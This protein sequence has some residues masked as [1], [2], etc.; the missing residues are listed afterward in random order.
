MLL[1]PLAVLLTSL[2]P[3]MLAAQQTAWIKV[4]SGEAASHLLKKVDPEY[5]AF[6]KAAGIQ[7]IVCM[8][9]DI[10]S[11]GHVRGV[12]PVSGSP[13]LA[14]AAANA[15]TQYLYKPFVKDGKPV[16][17]TAI[18][19][20]RFVLPAGI[21]PRTYELPAIASANFFGR[22]R[23]TGESVAFSSLSSRLQQWFRASLSDNID[24]SPVKSDQEDKFQEAIGATTVNL[25]PGKDPDVRVYL[26]DTEG[27]GF[28]GGPG[29]N[30]LV[31]LVEERESE[32]HLITRTSANGY[33]LRP[34][35]GSA[36]PDVFLSHH[37]GMLELD[38]WGYSNIDGRWG[39]LYCGSIVT[40]PPD[41]PDAGKTRVQICP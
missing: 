11:D 32:I 41:G 6:A 39:Q 12:R 16:S 30:C 13:S 28:C 9:V 35:P 14:D 37:M 33:F 1:R 26:F 7:G 22:G 36:Y 40:N 10:Y 21:V 27:R 17:T 5:P 4:S 18:V 19:E 23:E 2:F 15:L 25:I 34:H 24:T 20:I 31:T 29:A 38:F 3:V 8:S